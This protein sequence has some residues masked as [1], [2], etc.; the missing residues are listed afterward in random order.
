MGFTTKAYQ[1]CLVIISSICINFSLISTSQAHF[2]GHDL[3]VDVTSIA[4]Y[5]DKANSNNFWAEMILLNKGPH[6]I[7]LKGVSA[8]FAE[9]GRLIELS[10]GAN[11]VIEELKL[12]TNQ[13]VSVRPPHYRIEFQG[14]KSFT[15]PTI[16]LDFGS[17][18]DLN[19]TLTP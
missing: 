3:E 2:G 9:D 4:V 15:A 11:K 14:R 17:A 19:I 13:P 12:P 10:N 16:H 1:F 18:G 6:T 5:V 8:S 7:V